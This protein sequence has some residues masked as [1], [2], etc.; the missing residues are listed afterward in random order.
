MD[1]TCHVT[2]TTSFW[3]SRDGESFIGGFKKRWK[4]METAKVEN[5]LK[6]LPIKQNRRM[7]S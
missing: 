5:F 1:V 6:S 7:W 3:S 2:S 4:E